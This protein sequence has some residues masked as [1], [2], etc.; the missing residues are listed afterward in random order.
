[1][2]DSWSPRSWRECPADQQPPRKGLGD[3]IAVQVPG[4]QLAGE[5]VLAGPLALDRQ[6]QTTTTAALQDAVEL[7]ARSDAMQP[8]V[9]L[10]DH[11]LQP[12]GVYAAD[13]GHLQQQVAATGPE[14]EVRGTD[15][16]AQPLAEKTIVVTGALRNYTRQS[17]KDTI[18]RLG[19]KAS[20]SVSAKTSFVLVG[21]SPGSKLDKAQQLGVP[22]VTEEEF[23]LI[24]KGEKEAP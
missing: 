15:L 18:K 8:T 21:E 23:D 9:G 5:A 1:M 16:Q 6:E 10:S 13:I 19:G 2:S 22:I 17:I 3:R 12:A 4:A 11:Q 24:A 7:Q 14:R 20:S